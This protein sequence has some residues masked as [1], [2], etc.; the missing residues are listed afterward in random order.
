[1]IKSEEEKALI[2]KYEEFIEIE[3]EEI[4]KVSKETLEKE[5]KDLDEVKKKF[6]KKKSSRFTFFV[7]NSLEKC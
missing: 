4:K 5:E 3:S 7:L 6:F 1:M 2:R